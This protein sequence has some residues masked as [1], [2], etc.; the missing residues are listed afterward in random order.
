MRPLDFTDAAVVLGSSRSDGNTRMAVDL[1]LAGAPVEV[2]DLAR[3]DIGMY[4]Y[5]HHNQSDDFLPLVDRLAG[6]SLWI[7]A[8]PVYWYSMSA[9]MKVFFDRLSDLVTIRKAQ[10]RGLAG[11]TVALISSG[12]DPALPEGFEAP[13]RQT[14]EYLG[15]RYAGAFYAQFGDDRAPLRDH[16]RDAH[17]FMTRLFAARDRRPASRAR[18]HLEKP[19]SARREEFLA[20]VRR[21]AALH[22]RFV[23]PPA[24]TLAYAAW[25]KRLRPATHEGYFVVDSATDGL[26]GVINLSEIVRGSLQSGY[27][28][29]YALV[30]HA[31]GG[32]M[33]EGMRLVLRRAFGELRLHRVEANVQPDN[34]ASIEFVRR[35]GFTREG[36][37][38]RY[39]RINRRWRDHERWA[40]L[41]E[42]WHP[43]G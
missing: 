26:A 12:T 31:G 6:K 10:G 9:R 3:L 22:G 21:S 16:S 8:T 14:C 4:D 2:I 39:L 40:L 37:S 23:A 5:G 19:A 20:A 32:L 18:V 36:Y 38:R 25:L 35:L 28:G 34:A 43:G 33:S 15:M 42:N 11:K 7:L 41:R 17:G 13:F 27:L 1:V 30:P 29:Y 24:T